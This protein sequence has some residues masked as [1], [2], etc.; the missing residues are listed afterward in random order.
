MPT[1]WLHCLQRRSGS[2]RRLCCFP[3]AGG[4]VTA[5]AP[6]AAR[7]GPDHEI[8]VASLP[9]RGPRFDEPLETALV[10]LVAPLADALD[11]AP[12]PMALF[13]GHSMGALLAF[14]TTRELRRRRHP[15]P[16][17]L[18]VSG[19]RAPQRFASHDRRRHLLDRDGLLAHLRRLGGVPEEVLRVPE[20]LDLLLPIVRADL[21][22]CETHPHAVEPPLDVPM[23]VLH[24]DQDPE[25]TAEEVAA[26]REQTTGRC[27]LRG[28]P[29]GHFFLDGH[30]AEVAELVRGVGSGAGDDPA[31]G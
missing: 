4:A 20:L 14:E 28:F 11:H 13:L 7:L 25:A 22:A 12:G 8:W 18:V 26:W 23:L 2:P 30:W 16:A 5:Y 27:T 10:S 29:G 17:A 15:L 1:P 9:G 19:A 24:G 21:A 6:L 31:G 3:H